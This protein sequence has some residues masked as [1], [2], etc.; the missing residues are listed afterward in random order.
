M[1]E[2]MKKRV[3][4]SIVLLALCM[5]QGA[6]IVVAESGTLVM[7]NFEANKSDLSA[8]LLRLQD[9]LQNIPDSEL[10]KVEDLVHE[11]V[12]VYDE[13]DQKAFAKLHNAK[14]KRNHLK[15]KI[16][17]LARGFGHAQLSKNDTNEV[18]HH[19]TKIEK[20]VSKK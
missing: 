20:L 11:I 16:Q 1:E 10:K 8:R 12:E 6:G 2:K 14:D 7:T 13:A 18:D 19:I 5:Q 17:E 15:T 9:Q 3:N 4:S